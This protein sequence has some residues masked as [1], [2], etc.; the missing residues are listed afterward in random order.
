MMA[1]RRQF[2][3]AGRSAGTRNSGFLRWTSCPA[4]GP[5]RWGEPNSGGNS[6]KRALDRAEQKQPIGVNEIEDITCLRLSRLIRVWR[7]MKAEASTL[8]VD[9]SIAPM[10]S[11]VDARDIR[12]ALEMLIETGEARGIPACRTPRRATASD[13]VC[14]NAAALA[15]SRRQ[16]L[17]G[18]RHNTRLAPGRTSP[19]RAGGD[20]IRLR[21]DLQPFKTGAAKRSGSLQGSAV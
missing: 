3:A 10:K 5:G 7:M 20:R 16:P 13:L 12:Q 8:G 2:C 21:V 9:T 14:G 17:G 11:E 4:P 18:C 15:R 1:G 19:Y 6:A